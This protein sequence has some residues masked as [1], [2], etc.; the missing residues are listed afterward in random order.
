MFLYAVNNRLASS[1][2]LVAALFRQHEFDHL[3]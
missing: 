2:A 3:P 1:T